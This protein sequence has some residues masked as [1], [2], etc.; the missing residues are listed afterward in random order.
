MWFRIQLE[1]GLPLLSILIGHDGFFY[2]KLIDI[3]R[4]LGKENP[5]VFR[6][7]LKYFAIE[8]KMSYPPLDSTFPTK[9]FKLTLYPSL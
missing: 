6:N 7:S 5:Y 8:G 4:L 3:G 9:P 2:V 1:H